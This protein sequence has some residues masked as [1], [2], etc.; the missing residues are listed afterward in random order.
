MHGGGYAFYAA[1]SRHFAEML[2]GTLGMKL[3]ASAYRLT[4]EHP[5]PA[6]I[7][8]ALAAYRYLLAQGTDPAQLVIIGDSAGG[9]LTLMTL[10]AL[11]D[12]GLPQPALAVGLCPWTDIGERGVSLTANNRYDLMQGYMAIPFGKWLLGN[13]PYSRK[14]LS[15]VYQ[16]FRGLAPVYLQGGGK[17]V[18][19]DQIRDFANVLVEQGCDVMLDVWKHMTHDFQ[20]YGQTLPESKEALERIR[21]AIA[22]RSGQE[23]AA[24]FAAGLRTEI[25]GAP[26]KTG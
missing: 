7:E 14:D 8:D 21:E 20:G 11:R 24:P 10:R 9:H 19:I 25:A 23:S 13:G 1:V 26:Q 2:S 12:A 15:P 5:H 6:Q 16:Q 17:E 4:P 18:L 22:Y 3:F